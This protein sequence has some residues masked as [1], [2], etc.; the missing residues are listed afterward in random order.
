MTVTATV[1]MESGGVEKQKRTRKTHH[2][3]RTGCT[4]CKIRRKK[5]DETK[6][7]C[8]RCTSTGR[9]CDGY[10]T[11]PPLPA[12]KPATTQPVREPNSP[13]SGIDV[14]SNHPT[15]SGTTP[16]SSS[17]EATLQSAERDMMLKLWRPPKSVYF[18]TESDYYCFDFFRNRTGPEF[19][20]YF[21]SSIWRSFMMRACFLHPTVLQAAAAVGAVHRRFELGITSQAFTFCAIANRQYAKAMRCLQQDMASKHPAA[22]E[23]NMLT[24]MLLSVFESFQGN[25]DSALRH[26]TKGL[27]HILRRP[28]R[29][30]H[31]ESHYKAVAVGYASLH[32]LTDRLE[33]VAPKFFASDTVILTEPAIDSEATPIPTAFTSLHE[34]RDL[35][36]SETAW[37]YRAWHDLSMGANSGFA[38][39]HR[40]I[41]RLLAWSMAYAEYSK[42]DT[43][44]AT[45][46]A[47]RAAHLLKAYR[48]TLYLVL[49]TQ[50]AFH[51]PDTGE[52]IVPLCFPPETCDCHR[53]CRDYAEKKSAL[54]AHLARI[55]VLTEALFDERSWWAYE[56]HSISVDSGI[57]PPVL[58]GQT[59]CSS[60]KVR[61]QVTGLLD[62]GELRD[63]VWGRLGVYSVAEKLS[64]IEEHAVIEAVGGRKG[65]LRGLVGGGTWVNDKAGGGGGWGGRGSDGDA[66]MEEDWF[67]GQPN[68]WVGRKGLGEPKWVDITCFMDEGKLLVRHCREDEL[69]GLVWTQEW[70]SFT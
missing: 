65:L 37:I 43:C 31:S 5:C 59:K 36:F 1:V 10:D 61:H 19:A 44:R 53:S 27:R 55:L 35:L 33:R 48:E 17:R 62:Q 66:A 40:Q 8:K 30:T 4:T 23:I 14:A 12:A 21:D 15:K 51:S 32:E 16:S 24:H 13:D 2:K 6:P 57:G 47:R 58:M 54:N 67:K 11:Q 26:M 52:E 9:K 18:S 63:Q 70:V 38:A 46:W 42:T 60:T 7:A 20:A 68:W 64:S 45:P 49:L 56:E 29:T 39:Q 34:A 50:M 69:G 25:Y 22:P 28:T 41:A 3:V